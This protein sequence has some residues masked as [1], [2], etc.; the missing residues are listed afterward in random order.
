MHLSS[1]WL[2]KVSRVP[3]ARGFE[4]VSLGWGLRI[5]ILTSFQV[6]QMLSVQGLHSENHLSGEVFTEETQVWLAAHF[7]IH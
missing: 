1:E 7:F 4:L 3:T 6:T 2:I 5:C